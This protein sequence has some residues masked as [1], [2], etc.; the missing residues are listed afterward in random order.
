MKPHRHNLL[1]DADL[2]PLNPCPDVSVES[3]ASKMRELRAAHNKVALGFRERDGLMTAWTLSNTLS[4]QDMARATG[5]AKSRVDQIVRETY[6]AERA[7][8]AR[9]H[10][11]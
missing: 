2:Q 8:R 3:Q 7:R 11:A 6:E 10:T 1:P 9:K 5:L 4:R